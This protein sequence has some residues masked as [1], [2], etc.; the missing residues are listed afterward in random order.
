M[1]ALPFCGRFGICLAT[2]ALML[3]PTAT[4]ADEVQ[5]ETPDK[6]ELHGTFYPGSKKT[7]CVILLHKIGGNRQQKGWDDLAQDLKKDYA[8]LSFDFRGHGDSRSVSQEFWSYS[9]NNLIKGAAKKPNKIDYM[10]FPKNYYPMLAN[11]VL[12]AKRYLDQQNDAGSCNSSNVIVVGAEDGAAVGALWIASEFQRFKLVKRPIGIPVLDSTK[13][14]GEDIA[15]AVWLSIPK[16]LSNIDVSQWLKGG[17]NRVRDKVSM[18][19]IFGD[20]DTKAAGAAGFLFNALKPAGT[21]DKL[22]FTATR[23]KAT[24]LE[25]AELLGKKGLKTEEDIITYLEKVMQKRGHK[26]WIQRDPPPFG[27]IQLRLFGVNL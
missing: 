20:K 15:A 11:D 2:L 17:G 5:F 18:V 7:P 26:P 14:E 25:G 24:K 12:A 4:R 9:S 23:S 19:F 10:D 3:V 22:E 8:V 16:T 1:Q 13:I 6:V 21:K 27:L